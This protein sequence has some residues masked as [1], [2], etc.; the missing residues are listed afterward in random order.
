MHQSTSIDFSSS[1]LCK[2]TQF[3][4]VNKQFPQCESLHLYILKFQLEWLLLSN[5]LKIF[6]STRELLFVLSQE[7]KLKKMEFAEPTPR[8]NLP[9]SVQLFQPCFWILLIWKC[10]EITFLPSTSLLQV[11]AVKQSPVQMPSLLCQ[12][13]RQHSA[14]GCVPLLPGATWSLS[15][16]STRMKEVLMP[17]Q[18]Y[19]ETWKW[20]S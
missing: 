6:K 18:T 20:L 14:A 4:G 17:S 7:K 2:S 11:S 3:K 9:S 19:G 5:H 8:L 1:Q 12:P 15:T 16:N 13:W 10:Q